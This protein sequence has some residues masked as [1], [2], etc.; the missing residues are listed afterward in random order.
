MGSKTIALLGIAASAAFVYYCVDMKKTEIAKACHL[1]D[2]QKKK[3]VVQVEEPIPVKTTETEVA[4]VTEKSA[5]PSVEVASVVKSDPAFGFMMGEKANI[6]GMFAP[7]AKDKALMHF[8]DAYCSDRECIQ[9]IRFSEDIKIVNWHQ[10]IIDLINF[11]NEEHIEKGSLYINSN[12]V[13]I[14][15]EI[16]NVDQKKRL[17]SLIE[18]LKKDGLFVEDETISMISEAKIDLEEAEKNE[19]KLQKSEETTALKKEKIAETPNETPAVTA[20]P[21]VTPKGT[22][23]KQDKDETEPVTNSVKFDP[24]HKNQLTD[25]S[26]KTVDEMIAKL[27]GQSGIKVEVLGYSDS[28]EGEIYNNVVSQKRADLVKNYLARHGIR[29]VVSKGMG[30]KRSDIEAEIKIEK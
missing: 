28:S 3:A 16:T 8:I 19:S 24:V 23:V 9:D 22:D 20:E 30:S 6:V 17:E 29:G 7:E 10:A 21:S 1:F 4:Q 13:H 14:E 12:V 25:E 18:K 26:K 11:F 15:G 27:K 5:E 2:S